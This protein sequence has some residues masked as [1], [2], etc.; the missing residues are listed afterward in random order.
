MFDVLVNQF[1]W[2]ANNSIYTLTEK[3]VAT[4][5]VGELVD[6][7]QRVVIVFHMEILF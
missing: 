7:F 2:L 4:F 1:E 5:R 3:L 6:R